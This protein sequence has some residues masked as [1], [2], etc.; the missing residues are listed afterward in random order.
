MA[1]VLGFDDDPVVVHS[2]RDVQMLTAGAI[3]D[4]SEHLGEIRVC[5][6]EQGRFRVLADPHGVEGYLGDAVTP[7]S[8][9]RDHAVACV[10]RRDVFGF[11]TK[12]RVERA[13]LAKPP[14]REHVI[15]KCHRLFDGKVSQAIEDGFAAMKVDAVQ[16][17][18]MMAEDD[19]GAGFN[20][21]VCDVSLVVGDDPGHEVYAP[22]EGYCDVIGRFSRESHVGAQGGEIFPVRERVRTR[23][24]A[25]LVGFDLLVHSECSHGGASRSLAFRPVAVGH[26]RAVCEKCTA[27]SIRLDDGRCTRRRRRQSCSA[28]F[29]AGRTRARQRVLE[30]F[31]SPVH[32]VVAGE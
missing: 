22:V 17:V 21:R 7:Q 28:K 9:P 15:R 10:G 24:C 25:G 1:R 29:E 32:A 5:S 11:G 26:D 19:I 6:I 13:D 8:K 20:G 4:I 27:D 14:A 23:R 3:F 12:V 2:K 16:D 18:R 30:R 31:S